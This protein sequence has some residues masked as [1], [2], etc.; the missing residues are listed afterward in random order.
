MRRSLARTLLAALVAVPLTVLAAPA[1]HASTCPLLL[2]A[3]NDAVLFTPSLNANDLDVRSADIASGT[4]NVVAV[5]R[6]TTLTPS[7]AAQVGARWA[8]AWQ[9][10][11]VKYAFL[12]DRDP[13]GTYTPRI[14]NGGTAPVQVVVDFTNATITW[15]APRTAFGQLATAGQTF[16]TITASGSVMTPAGVTTTADAAFTT[17]TYVDQTAGCI[18]AT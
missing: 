9:V 4:T 6:L 2:D 7:N 8:V 3:A 16:D 11:G 10:N 14:A 13:R 15:T 18:P 1:A 17:Q 5:L 12:L